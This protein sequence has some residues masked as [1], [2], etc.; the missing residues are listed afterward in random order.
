M[1]PLIFLALSVCT[2]AECTPPTTQDAVPATGQVVDELDRR[3]W[4]S[5]QDRRGDYWFGSNGNGVYRYDGQ[6]VIQYTRADGLGG[7]QVRDIEEDNEGNVFISTNSAV[8]RFDG[9][10]FTT[11]D[12]VEAPADGSA[13]A[14]DPDDVWLVFDPGR[15]GPCRYDGERLYHLTLSRSPAEDALSRSPGRRFTPTGVYSIYKDRRGHMWFGTAGVGLCRYDGQ[16]L[17][18]VYEE[19]LTTTPSGGAFGIR[20]V[21]QDRSGDYWICNTRQRFEMSTD[22]TVLD[23]HRMVKYETKEGLPDARSDTDRNFD[24][25]PSMTEDHEGALWM[26]CGNAGVWKFD[27][28]EVTKYGLSDGAWAITIYCDRRGKLW[29]G[30]VEHGVYTFGGE[31]FELFVPDESRKD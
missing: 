7:D 8:T 27:G 28:E 31:S 21:Y 13:W 30:T 9:T 26:A 22:I 15:Y 6:R 24:Y 23:G 5:Y 29:T 10:G 16:G 20:S 25:F 4:C 17:S 11:L 3:I 14:L 18:W 12:L 1:R 2:Q 19:R